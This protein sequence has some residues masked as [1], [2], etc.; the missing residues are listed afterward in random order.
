[1]H[2]EPESKIVEAVG[3]AG[4][5]N[6]TI[7]LTAAMV[8]KAMSEA[9]LAAQAEGIT[10]PDEIRARKLAARQALK[11]SVRAE[12]QRLAEEAKAKGE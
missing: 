2:D 11:D 6:R 8:E 10:D 12:Q 1:M 5:G 9:T 4:A 7:G 3:A